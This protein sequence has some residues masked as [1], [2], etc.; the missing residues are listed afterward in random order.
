MRGIM[1]SDITPQIARCMSEAD[2]KA[3]GLLPKPQ[4]KPQIQ[5]KPKQLEQTN[6][7]NHTE[8]EALQVLR[9]HLLDF[10]GRTFEVV[11]HSYTPDWYGNGF[12]VEVKGEFIHSRDSRI[13]FDA[14]RLAHPEL[15]WIWARKRTKGRAGPRWDIQVFPASK[16]PDH[17]KAVS[18]S[19]PP[20]C[21]G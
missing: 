16:G 11:G 12:A 17:A 13:L 2:R 4:D 19:V 7:A 14:A 5:N 20:R 6:K 15:T 3:F 21:A 10:E 18:D 1:P 9:L 8:R